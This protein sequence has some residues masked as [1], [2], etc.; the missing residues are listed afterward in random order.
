MYNECD[1]V[2][3]DNFIQKIGRNPLLYKNGVGQYDPN[4]NLIKE[5]ASKYECIKSFSMSDKTLAKALDQNIMYNQFYFRTI[6]AKLK[7]L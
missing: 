2:L 7:C 6:Q 3:I 5:F 4:N 1:S